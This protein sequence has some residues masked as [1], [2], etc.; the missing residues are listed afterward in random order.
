MYITYFD[1]TNLYTA[2]P[3][4]DHAFYISGNEHQEYKYAA[5]TDWRL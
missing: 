3:H 5:L 2:T 1:I 4:R